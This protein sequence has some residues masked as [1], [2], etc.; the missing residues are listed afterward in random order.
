MS[1]IPFKQGG[2]RTRRS[3]RAGR[4]RPWRQS[5][6]PVVGQQRRAGGPRQGAGRPVPQVR[7]DSAAIVNLP[8]RSL[9]RFLA[10]DH[11]PKTILQAQSPPLKLRPRIP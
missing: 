7:N 9:A 8:A 4:T 1:H 5:L 10:A 3:T 11:W 2:G 6:A